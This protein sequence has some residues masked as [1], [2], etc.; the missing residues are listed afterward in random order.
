MV[1]LPCTFLYF[2]KETVIAEHVLKIGNQVPTT[3]S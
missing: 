3:T 1:G 2:E